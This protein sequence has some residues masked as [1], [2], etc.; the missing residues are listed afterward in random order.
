M[1]WVHP[2]PG[3]DTKRGRPRFLGR[4]G[5]RFT[6]LDLLAIH[7]SPVADPWHALLNHCPLPRLDH[8]AGSRFLLR[9]GKGSSHHEARGPIHPLQHLHPQLHPQRGPI[10]A[11]MLPESPAGACFFD[12]G[13]EGIYLHHRQ[14]EI[15]D[16]GIGDLFR[17]RRCGTQPPPYGLILMARDLFSGAQTPPAHHHQQRACHLHR[18]VAQAVHRRA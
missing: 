13:P 12:K 14:V 18:G 4:C 10:L 11:G 17:L 6:R 1:A 5:S 9:S 2:T 8:H 16:Q 3:V 7:L 15:M